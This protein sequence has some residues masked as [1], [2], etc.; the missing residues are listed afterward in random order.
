MSGRVILAAVALLAAG[1]FCVS[2]LSGR[3][4]AGKPIVLNAEPVCA[5]VVVGAYQGARESVPSA[6][7]PSAAG[8]PQGGRK[9]VPL[10]FVPSTAAV[11]QATREFVRSSFGKL[12]L[13]FVENR[14]VYPDEVAFTIQGA[15]K[16]LFFTPGGITMRLRG[17]D[18]GWVVKLEFVDAEPVTPRGEEPQ[19][20]VFSYF[21]GPKEDWKTGL[22]TYSRVVYENLWP[23]IDLVYRGTLN[24]LKYEFLVKPGADPAKIRLRYRGVESL[25]RTATGAL[26]VKTLA[27]GFE[28]A[29]PEAWQEIDGQRVLVEMAYRL[30]VGGAGGESGTCGVANCTRDVESMRSVVSTRSAA[31]AAGTDGR[32]FG[33]H[34]GD[35]DA[36]KPLVLDPAI[37][38]YCGYIGG[39][40]VS[41]HGHGIAFDAA[42][43][44]YVTGETLSSEQ[45]FP[46]AVGPDLVYNGGAYD[47]F[48]AKV[49]PSGT[50]LVYCGYIGGSDIE[51]GSG[52]AVDQ[53]GNAYISG[54]TRSNEQTFPVLLGPDLTYNGGSSD[55]FAAKV[56][57]S[58]TGLVY[59]GYIG[60]I[61]GEGGCGV[62]LD[63]VGNAYVAG[64]TQSNE[65]TFPVLSGPDLTYNGGVVD[66]FVAKVSAVGTGLVYC[67]YIGGNGSE[68]ASGIAV[69]RTGNAYVT[70][71]TWS[72]GQTFPVLVGPDLTHNGGDDVFVAKVNAAGTALVYCGYIGGSRED[73]GNGIAVDAAG[74]AYVTDS[75]CSSE[76]TFPVSCGPDLIHNGGVDAFVAKV[77]RSGS[78]L[79]YCGYIGGSKDESGRGIAV[80]AVGNAYVAG[81]TQ[82]NEQ[83]FP[84][85]VGPDLTYNGGKFDGFVAEVSAAGK[86]FVYC[87]YIGGV[88][89]DVGYGIAV[90]AVG[91]AY[92]TGFTSSN[93]QTFPVL[94]G[95]DLTHNGGVSDAFVAKVVGTVL[96]GS[97]SP[98]PGGK[99]MLSFSSAA[100]SGLRYQLGSSF[101]NGPI[102]IGPWKLE[103]SPDPMLVL[104]TSGAAPWIFQNYAGVLDAKG[105]ATAG[106]QI[107]ILPA[108]KGTRIYTAFV[109]LK[110]SAP[111]GIASVSNTFVFTIQ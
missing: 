39:K 53:A 44:A 31:S 19:E 43:H 10:A 91:N 50:G 11:P 84:V 33:F 77:T 64:Y 37:L 8:E 106:I 107:P 66:A 76:L 99:V 108:L 96:T 85:S 61:C 98:S 70:G 34:V 5:P 63:T 93:E 51:C 75:T 92:V 57:A 21:K 65:Q 72:T 59:C 90:D 69:D 7:A 56:N 41:D 46:V 88:F 103:L 4:A 14:G 87:G 49:T 36:T 9:T 2:D 94:V 86:S 82:S 83:T 35:Y 97:G 74:H 25:E 3:S 111:Y 80:D 29:P 27:G 16:T 79:V 62:A 12:P 40:S 110:A 15:D 30:E 109:T 54:Y 23:G 20:A 100:D 6:C 68:G 42:G 105:Q 13:Y 32:S 28:D 71:Q 95:P 1:V 81:D 60:G 52:I 78:A 102:M 101:G 22:R 45:T 18:Q 89:N 47:A 55:A 73:L 104:S 24:R 48:V 26:S 17:K 67:G 58:G 38:V